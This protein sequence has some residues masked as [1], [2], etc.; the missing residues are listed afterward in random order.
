MGRAITAHLDRAG[1]TVVGL[2]RHPEQISDLTPHAIKVDVTDPKAV[3]DA[4][5][6]VRRAVADVDLW[7]YA[8]GTIAS[9]RVHEMSPETWTRLLGANLTGAYLT[10]HYSLPLFTR[11]AHLFYLSAYDDRLRLPGLT[12]YAA[13]KAGLAAFTDA[14][15]KE[16]RRNKITLVRL[17]AVKT[18]LWNDV[19]FKL[20]ADALEPEAV[21]ERILRAFE[22]GETGKLD[23]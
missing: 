2:T 16:Q 21:A 22:E 13:S 12:A 20:P 14:L 17:A 8:V 19:P 3:E 1:W 10:T 6:A 18:E 4:I 15:A 11:Q 23:L 5:G 9:S 7:V